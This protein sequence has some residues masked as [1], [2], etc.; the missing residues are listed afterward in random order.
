MPLALL[1]LGLGAVG[2]G[3]NIAGNSEDAAAMAKVR[4]DFT[5]KQALLQQQS[6][7]IFQNSLKGSTPAIAGQQMQA[8][9]NARTSMWNQLQSATTPVASAL[10]ATGAASP[11]SKAAARATT[12]GNVFN[13]MNEGASA[14]EGSYGDWENQQAIKNADAAQKLGVV[15]NFASGNSNLLPT[16]LQVASQAGSKLSGW[17]SIVSSLGALTGLAGA[18]GAFGGAAGAADAV[19]ANGVPIANSINAFNEAGGAWNTVL[20]AVND[21]PLAGIYG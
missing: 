15:T 8:G 9:Q 11:T 6:N 20:P 3:L 18:S 13:T 1:G 16:E 2:T 17:G 19:D 12:A 14:R 21:V 10:P 4:A 7:D 5:R